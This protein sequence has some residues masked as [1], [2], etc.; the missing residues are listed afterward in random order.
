MKPCISSECSR[1]VSCGVCQ[2][3][4][5]C[6]RIACSILCSESGLVSVG[7]Q[8]LEGVFLPLPSPFECRNL[9][10]SSSHS[11]ALRLD[12]HARIFFR[13]WRF[14]TEGCVYEACTTC[15]KACTMSDMLHQRVCN[16]RNL[17]QS[18][19]I[20]SEQHICISRVIVLTHSSGGEIFWV[21][22]AF[23]HIHTAVT[24][25]ERL[26]SGLNLSGSHLP[27]AVITSTVL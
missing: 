9:K 21:R 10:G 23:G 18:A 3:L 11:P 15:W 19:V 27:V 12:R 22:L 16:S 6:S 5:N 8:K 4:P 20:E 14:R 25:K 7:A 17:Q 2:S 26:V 24:D 1:P 13:V